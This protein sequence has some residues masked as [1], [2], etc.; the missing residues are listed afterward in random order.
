MSSE[1]VGYIVNNTNSIL[2][3]GN[4]QLYGYSALSYARNMLRIG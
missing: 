2:V 3:L 1:T 4:R